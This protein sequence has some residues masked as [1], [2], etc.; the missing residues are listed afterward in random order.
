MT[1]REGERLAIVETELRHVREAQERAA[2]VARAERKAMSD[3]LAATRHD[4][5]QLRDV[6]TKAS[7]FK[8]AFMMLG[9][10]ATIA[11]TQLWNYLNWK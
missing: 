10:G 1:E 3:E 8:M 4:I 5:Q 6:L 9:A 11:L 2:E 7:G